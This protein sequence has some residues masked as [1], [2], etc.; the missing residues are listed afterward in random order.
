MNLSVISRHVAFLLAITWACYP[1]PAISQMCGATCANPKSLLGLSE[2]FLV[3]SI[4]ELRKADKPERGPRSSLGKWMLK[5]AYFATQAFTA[6][7]FVNSGLISRIRYL[8]S[9]PKSQCSKR[10][11]F[12]MALTELKKE[13]GE[14]AMGEAVT[15][16][17]RT[18]Q[19]VR[20]TKKDI[21]VSLN[22]SMLINDC[23]TRLVYKIMNLKDRS[24]Q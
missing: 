11:P 13:F 8:S 22:F 18:T 15:V 1:T 21:D 17:G 6:T 7:Y 4:P 9:A 14:G 19:T 2:Q 16:D 24:S 10:I 5:D 20:F 12:E 23:S 3:T